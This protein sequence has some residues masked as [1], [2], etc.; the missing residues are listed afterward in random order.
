[1]SDETPIL[2]AAAI[3]RAPKVLLHDHLDGGL[4]PATVLELAEAGGYTGL[5]ETGAEALNR[6]FVAAAGSG[7]LGPYLQTFAHT[8]GVLQTEDAL[9]RVAAEA[10]EDLAEDGVVY[11]EIRYAPELFVEHGLS[12][13]QVIEA[14][15]EG[16]AE[17]E[18]RAAAKGRTIRIATLLCAMRQLSRGLE[19]ATLAVR[20]R[21]AGVAGFDLA[22]PEAGFPPGGIS[23]VFDY[24]RANNAHFTIHAGEDFGLPSISD[25]LHL[26]GAERLGHAVRIVDDIKIDDAGEVHLGR[27]ASYVRDTRIPLELCPSSNVQTGVAASIAEHPFGL[28]AR[29]RFRVTINTDN[30]LMSGCD[31]SSEFEALRDAFGYGAEDFRRFT[32]NAAKSAFLDFDGRLDLIDN[33]ILP[34]YAELMAD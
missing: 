18:R 16:F 34:G 26:C 30:R 17:G 10:A 1:M 3:R 25:A 2:S 8:C 31:L 15:Q 4:R 33:V 27:L 23:H 19:I 28:L 13:D 29:L 9:V 22:G 20:Y 21:D 24:L 14:V 7:S 5:P 6:W 12:L 11:A 32:L